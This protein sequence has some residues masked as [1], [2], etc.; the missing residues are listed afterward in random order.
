MMATH[1]EGQVE[2]PLS[3]TIAILVILVVI[4]LVI[5]FPGLKSAWE[6]VLRHLTECCF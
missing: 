1:Q 6:R 4:V 3:L 2:P 5:A